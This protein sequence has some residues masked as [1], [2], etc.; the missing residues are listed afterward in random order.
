MISMLAALMPLVCSNREV[1]G[2]RL[3]GISTFPK[4]YMPIHEVIEYMPCLIEST[5]FLVGSPSHLCFPAV[6]VAKEGSDTRPHAK[7]SPR[8]QDVRIA[9]AARESCA[10][11]NE[12]EWESW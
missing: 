3:S 6:Y 5:P 12:P 10:R 1:R 2:G 11:W 9:G 8:S 7:R 4:Q